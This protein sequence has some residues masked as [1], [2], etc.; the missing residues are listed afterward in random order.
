MSSALCCLWP[1]LD[2]CQGHGDSARRCILSQ[3]SGYTSP[4]AT[5][6]WLCRMPDQTFSFHF[7]LQG[8]Q[9]IMTF[10]LQITSSVS[11]RRRLI[12]LA[13]ITSTNK[14]GSG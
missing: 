8:L 5:T 9:R 13:Q 6:A 14:D 12:F 2:W 1:L 7:F 3:D 4:F 10:R 11:S